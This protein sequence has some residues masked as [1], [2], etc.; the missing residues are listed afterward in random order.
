MPGPLNSTHDISRILPVNSR[1]AKND[2]LA[3][4]RLLKKV[5]NT[6]SRSKR[7]IESGRPPQA[8]NDSRT[9]SKRFI[10]R[11]VLAVGGLGLAAYGLANVMPRRS[12]GSGV[13]RP[14]VSNPL[15]MSTDHWAVNGSSQSGNETAVLDALSHDPQ[16]YMSDSLTQW[17]I[18]DIGASEVARGEKIKQLYPEV[19][20]ELDAGRQVAI[21]AL[22]VFK[23]RCPQPCDSLIPLTV[24]ATELV[25]EVIDVV[26]EGDALDRSIG[27]GVFDKLLSDLG[28]SREEYAQLDSYIHPQDKLVDFLIA[29]LENPCHAR[30]TGDKC[31]E[32]ILI[33]QTPEGMQLDK[34][35][36]RPLT[37]AASAHPVMS[38]FSNKLPIILTTHV[39]KLVN[40]PT[41]MAHILIHEMVHYAGYGDMVYANVDEAMLN[42]TQKNENK[43]YL[44]VYDKLRDNLVDRIDKVP[45]SMQPALMQFYDL[46]V[47][48]DQ[49][50]EVIDKTNYLKTALSSDAKLWSSFLLTNTDFIAM[51]LL[52]PYL[53]ENEM[54]RQLQESS[55]SWISFI[56]SA[57]EMYRF[58]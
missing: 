45:L 7:D 4:E 8:S 53:R 3:A 10:G 18:E 46:Y 30:T 23:T 29:L 1:T 32:Y 41:L 44:E 39:E 14:P 50:M 58:R 26:R 52:E 20:N 42:N 34:E 57:L 11:A 17:L 33:E 2:P 51:Y 43:V 28:V 5:K 36:N 27:D 24:N 48:G 56:T 37:Y 15:I 31:V 47:G 19:D 12:D 6:P 25:K 22:K 40:H 21:A 49:S 13:Q 9:L 55:K 16:G 54:E 38:L 35:N